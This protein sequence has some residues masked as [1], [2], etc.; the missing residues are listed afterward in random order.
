MR[1]LALFSMVGPLG[2]TAGVLISKIATPLMDAIIVAITAGTFLYVGAT[3]VVNEE[4]EDAKGAEKWKKF[5]AL[6]SGMGTIWAVT[7]ATQGWEGGGHDHS[8]GHSHAE[9]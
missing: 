9:L 2:V 7:H 4:F 8:H 5:A 6:L 1:W 3:E